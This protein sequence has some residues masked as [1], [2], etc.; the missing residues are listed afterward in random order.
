[1]V[2]VRI[3]SPA[4]PDAVA[5]VE[6]LDAYQK[7]LYPEESFYGIDLAEMLQPNVIFAMARM[8]D[9]AA[10]GCGAVVITEEGWG[11][12]KRMFVRPDLR[13]RGVAQAVVSFLEGEAM[14][15]G[16]DV[17]RLE[18]GISQPEALRFYE[19]AGYVRRGVFGRYANDPL[20]VFME[21]RLVRKMQREET[22]P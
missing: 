4:N 16:V 20:S 12:L 15:R 2:T 17:M 3:E 22:N 1:M 5:L 13:G 6:E 21:K 9:G 7:P 10:A 11:E 14:R 19:Q 18:T 8:P